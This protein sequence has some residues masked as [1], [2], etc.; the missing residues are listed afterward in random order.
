MSQGLC[1]F[2]HASPMAIRKAQRCRGVRWPA[3]TK[4]PNESFVLRLS[5]AILLKNVH[6][7]K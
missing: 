5:F 1:I 6:V 3:T 7:T 2:A 4:T